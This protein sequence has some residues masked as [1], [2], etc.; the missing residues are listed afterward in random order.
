[1]LQP[2]EEIDCLVP[3]ALVPPVGIILIPTKESDQAYCS[4]SRTPCCV[5]GCR[6]IHT[7]FT[8][9]KNLMALQQSIS[10]QHIHVVYQ[11]DESI[12]LKKLSE[13]PVSI[14]KNANSHCI[15]TICTKNKVG[16]VPVH[17]MINLNHG[18]DQV[19]YKVGSF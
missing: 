13:C 8:A 7:G 18:T 4:S 1:M 10:K 2:R 19:I 12:T 5:L 6:E 3:V 14:L 11:A 15:M 17:G 9:T 16:V